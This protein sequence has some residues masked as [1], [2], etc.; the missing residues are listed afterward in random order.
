MGF[1]W[2]TGI[3]NDCVFDLSGITGVLESMVSDAISQA[4]TR[5]GINI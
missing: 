3:R 5:F 2:R 1:I 4:Y